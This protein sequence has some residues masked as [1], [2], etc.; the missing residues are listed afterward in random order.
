MLKSLKRSNAVPRVIICEINGGIGNQ[1]FQLASSYCFAIKTGLE[2]VLDTRGCDSA[3]SFHGSWHLDLLVEEIRK[4]LPFKVRR[5]DN[6]M[7]T[8]TRK[9]LDF[10][11]RP[12]IIPKDK[13]KYQYDMGLK[14]ND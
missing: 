10:I 5:S 13:I 4:D 7:K 12:T 6:L 11:H 9:L 14:L 8:T 3:R 2:I 1:I